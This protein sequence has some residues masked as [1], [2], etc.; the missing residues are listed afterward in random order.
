MGISCDFGVNYAGEICLMPRIH[1]SLRHI[2]W[3]LPIL[4]VSTGKLWADDAAK[5]KAPPPVPVKVAEVQQKMVAEQV[6]LVG[7]TEAA[8]NALDRPHSSS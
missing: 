4:C 2:F 1:C 8:A 5:S 6:S 3:V 7:T